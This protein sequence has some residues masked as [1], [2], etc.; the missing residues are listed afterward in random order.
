[1]SNSFGGGTSSGSRS[2]T[3]RPEAMWAA[4]NFTDYLKSLNTSTVDNTYQNIANNAY[5][6]SSQLP[7]YV[8]SVDGSDAARQR[9]ENAVYNQAAGRLNKQF[10]E[11]MSALNTKLQN[12]GLSVGSTAYQNAV[13]SLQD[14]QYDALNN[15]AYESIIQGQNAFTNSLNNAVT[16]GNFTNNAR[17]QSLSEILQILQNSISGYQVQKD[18]FNAINSAAGQV[19]TQDAYQG[20]S[21]GLSVQD[22]VSLASSAATIAAA[23]SDIRLKENISPVGRLDKD[24]EGLL[25]FTDDG[26]LDVR[27][28]RPE[29]H[30]EKEYE[31]RAFGLLDETAMRQLET[32][33]LLLEGQ[34]PSLPARAQLLAHTSIGESAPYLPERFR[35]KYLKNPSRPVTTGKLWITEGRKHQVKLMI[36]AVGGH[37]FYLKRLAIGPVRLDEM[38]RPGEYRPLTAEELAALMPLATSGGGTAEA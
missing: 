33:V 35:E 29:Q 10:S 34:P 12:Q 3:A 13:S 4:N 30:V 28:L 8:Y 16:A 19:T 36:K 21:N 20:K 26:M 38:L 22:V 17:Q 32:G 7:N 15:A 23:V 31:Y 11:D 24:T 2:V 25:L 6:L 37:V 14:S 1:M 9:M 5:E 18:I 27:L